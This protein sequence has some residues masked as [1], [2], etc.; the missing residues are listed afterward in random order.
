MRQKSQSMLRSPLLR[1]LA[2]IPVVLPQVLYR[3]RVYMYVR[4]CAFP[5]YN[6]MTAV[7]VV[8]SRFCT[9]ATTAAAAVHCS[10]RSTCTAVYQTGCGVAGLAMERALLNSPG[11]FVRNTF[12]N[13]LGLQV[14]QHNTRTSSSSVFYYYY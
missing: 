3:T 2:L 12:G 11:V 5:T 9:A 4:E 1:D 10:G 7:T 6:V 8:V 14:R 13:I